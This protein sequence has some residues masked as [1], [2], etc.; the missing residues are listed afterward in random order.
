MNK[1]LFYDPTLTV[2][3]LSVKS[4][5]VQIANRLSMLLSHALKFFLIF[6]LEEVH[7]KGSAGHA[8]LEEGA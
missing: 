4:T 2:S 5:C 3:A 6:F 7:T 8:L 1:I